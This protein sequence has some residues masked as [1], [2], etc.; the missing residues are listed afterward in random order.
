MVYRTQA[1]GSEYIIIYVLIS[2]I[3]F[4]NICTA[5]IIRCAVTGPSSTPYSSLLYYKYITDTVYVCVIYCTGIVRNRKARHPVRPIS[6]F[7]VVT[8][9]RARLRVPGSSI[10]WRTLGEKGGHLPSSNFNSSS[11]GQ[12]SAISLLNLCCIN[13]SPLNQRHTYVRMIQTSI[14]FLF[15]G[16][17]RYSVHYPFI[18]VHTIS[19]LSTYIN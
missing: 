12:L 15:K 18:H 8:L 17:L 10:Q 2:S 11:T 1:N 14:L 6:A 4:S 5:S 7:P 3:D 13:L 16:W 9:L 19:Y